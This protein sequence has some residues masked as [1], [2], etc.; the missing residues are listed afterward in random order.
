MTLSTLSIRRVET[1]DHAA[2]AAIYSQYIQLGGVTL[3]GEPF[4]PSHVERLASSMGEREVLLVA[5]Q[6]DQV[7]GW[8]LVK[9][10]SNRIGYARCCE[11]SIYL[12]PTQRG[13]G[14]GRLLQERLM[15]FIRKSGFHHVVAK[16][17]AGN[18]G[19]IAFHQAFGFEVIGTQKEIGY[20]NDIWHDVVIMQC[21][22]PPH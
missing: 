17:L 22:I 11:T 9:L 13:K 14:Y 2:I 6:V 19:S 5:E 3:D 12:R 21:L 1:K 15:D 8:G 18:G 20:I 7:I 10:Y 16:I 4:T